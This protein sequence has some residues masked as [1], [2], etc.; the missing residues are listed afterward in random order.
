MRCVWG[1]NWTFSYSC[2][3]AEE[4]KRRAERDKLAAITALEERSREFMR[5]KRLKE[6]LEKKINTMQSQL[7]LG[8]HKIEDTPA[9]RILIDREHKRIRGAHSHIKSLMPQSV[10]DRGIRDETETVGE[11]ERRRGC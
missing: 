7:L 8:G 2:S 5:E 4:E 3:Q 6:K 1:S 11:R 10:H 9:F